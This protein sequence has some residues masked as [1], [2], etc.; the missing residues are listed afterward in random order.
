MD[1]RIC[2]ERAELI[3]DLG[4]QPFANA[5]LDRQ[6]EQQSVYP[7]KFYY[8]DSCQYG[9]TDNLSSTNIFDDTYPY[10]SSVNTSYVKQCKEWATKYKKEHNPQRVIEIGSNDGYMLENFKDSS[11]LGFEPSRGPFQ[12]SED[13]NLNVVNDF[14]N[15][16]AEK[17]DLIIANNVLAHTPKLMT[18]IGD[19]ALS[20]SNHGQAVIEF[21]TLENLILHT[22][23]DTI[24]HEHFS[25]FTLHSMV[26]ALN[27]HKLYLHYFEEIPSHG[28]SIRAYF[29]KQEDMSENINRSNMDIQ[30]FAQRVKL[31]KL[32]NLRTILLAKSYKYKLALFGAAAKGNTFLNYLGIGYDMFDFCVDETKYKQG[33]FLPGSRIPIVGMEELMLRKPEVLWILPWNFKEEIIKKCSFIGGWDGIFEVKQ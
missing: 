17:A 14:F 33:K 2:G 25:Y 23:Y 6:D 21:P 12:V 32:N 11:H 30:G 1:C 29:S 28:G 22:Q 31:S 20:L 13:K 9:M 19:I 18:M 15:G 5:L 10:Y 26:K 24:Y 3:L 8:C 16:V 4:Y 27:S 7:L